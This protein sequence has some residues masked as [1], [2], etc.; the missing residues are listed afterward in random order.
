[1]RIALTVFRVFLVV[2]LVLCILAQIVVLGA[3]RQ[4]APGGLRDLALYA[5]LLQL[6]RDG[7]IPADLAVFVLGI[8]ALLCVLPFLGRADAEPAAPEFVVALESDTVRRPTGVY[9]H[10]REGGWAWEAFFLGFLWYFLHRLPGRGLYALGVF[11]LLTAGLLLGEVLFQDVLPLAPTPLV[12][13]ADTPGATVTVSDVLD[14]L[15]RRG[16]LSWLVVGV[17]IGWFARRRY[18]LVQLRRLELPRPVVVKQR[19]LKERRRSLAQEL[20]DLT[21]R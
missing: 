21:R 12:L 1:M 16:W 9:Q 19:P 3:Q 13:K 5:Y 18:Y 10:L 17:S 14:Y 7:V 4:V 2:L 20:E 15:W 8:I 6:V 11:L